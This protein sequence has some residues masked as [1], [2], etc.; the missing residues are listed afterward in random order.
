MWVEPRSVSVLIRDAC[1]WCTSLTPLC[2]VTH[3][4]SNVLSPGP[5]HSVSDSAMWTDS[6]PLS[7]SSFCLVLCCSVSSGS[8]VSVSRLRQSSACIILLLKGVQ[9]CSSS[10]R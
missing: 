5:A 6:S 2:A 3:S 8:V 10:L 7:S 9:K 1:V 4:G